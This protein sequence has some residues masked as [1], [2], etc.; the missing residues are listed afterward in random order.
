MVYVLYGLEEFL[1]DKEIKKIFDTNNINEFSIE[2]YDLENTLLDSIIDS[3]NTLNMF[4]DKKGII[5]N[6][7]YI[8]TGNTKKNSLEHNVDIFIKYLEHSDENTFLIFKILSENL[9]ERKKIVKLIKEKAVVKEFNSGNN[10]INIVKGFFNDYTINNKTINLFIDRVGND[11]LLLEN[12]AEKL[13]IYKFESKMIDENDII[14]AVN[15]NVEL[16]IFSLIDNIVLKHKTEA[17]EIYNE[18]IKH[19]E[20]PIKIMIMLANQ[21]RIMYQVKLMYKKGYSEKD[22]AST[23]EIHP[24][25]IKLAFEKSRKF[26]E[27]VLISLLDELTDLDNKIKLGEADKKSSLELFILK[28]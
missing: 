4:S 5:V 3:C 2:K 27:N 17:I 26:E 10:I 25:R 23:L 1:I 13:K 22:M 19:G 15:K 18:M 11:L 28:L 21:F 24:Y 20:E 8:F 9:D 7:A 12:E 6:N 16:D 14:N